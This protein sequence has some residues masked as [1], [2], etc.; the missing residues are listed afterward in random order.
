MNDI[1]LARVGQSLRDLRKQRGLSQLELAARAGTTRKAVINAEK[2]SPGLSLGS[3]VALVEAM[4]AELA[5]VPVRRP[6]TEEIRS[7]LQ[8]QPH[9]A[10]T[11]KMSGHG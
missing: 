9:T 1:I 8:A 11:K 5:T 7:L 3:F 4:G 6:T 10:T 2:G